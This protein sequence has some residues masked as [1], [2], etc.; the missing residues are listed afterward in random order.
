MDLLK[1]EAEEEDEAEARELE[2]EEAGADKGKDVEI[3]EDQEKAH[4]NSE[5]TEDLLDE[6]QVKEDTVEDEKVQKTTHSGKKKEH[7][8]KMAES[9]ALPEEDGSTESV[10]PVDLDYA[11]DSSLL[12]PLQAASANVKIHSEDTKSSSKTEIPDVKE[13]ETSEKELVNTDDYGQGMQN[14]EAAHSEEQPDL[15]EDKDSPTQD[16]NANKE[17]GT[18]ANHQEPTGS[19]E[20]ESRARLSGEEGEKSK[21]DSGSHTKGKTRKQKKN[22]RARKHSPHRDE[23]QPEQE[24]SQQDPQESEGSN[25]DNTVQKPKRRRAG[26][27]VMFI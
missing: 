20:P 24:Q 18:D 3:T 22:Q 25:V 6:E 14:T 12:Q 19:A 16:T 26:K 21:N 2:E 5:T 1:K 10:I 7:T 15:T 17:P 4:S 27:W 11:A 23:A 8:A 9:D 13:K